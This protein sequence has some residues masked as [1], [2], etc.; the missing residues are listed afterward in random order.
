MYTY[1]HVYIYSKPA[2]KQHVSTTSANMPSHRS[3]SFI[4]GGF[5]TYIYIKREREREKERER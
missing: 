5:I 3:I 1:I 2:V 4:F